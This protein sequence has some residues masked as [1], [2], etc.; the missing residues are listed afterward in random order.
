MAQAIIGGLLDAGYSPGQL[1]AADPSDAAQAKLRTMGVETVTATPGTAFDSAGLIILAVKPQFMASA[2]SQLCERLAATTVVMSVAAGINT[3]SLKSLLGNP[4]LPVVRCMPNTPALIGVGACGLFA[5]AEVSDTQR[6][7]VETVMRVVGTA[8]WLEDEALIDV[9]TAV[10]GSGPAYFFAFMEAMISSGERLGLDR[11]TAS[12]LT[13]QTALG[14]ATLAHQSDSSIEALRI[15]VTSP[16]GTTE[17]ALASF[18]ASGLTALVDQGM[19]ACL[20]RA[21]AMA[22]EFG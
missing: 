10:S 6:M 22:E 14:A 17:R 1:C 3:Q 19:Q 9:V 12:R 11:E 8:Q 13:L 21:R 4:D 15:N 2:T 18:E 7:G 20:D 16:G 5:S